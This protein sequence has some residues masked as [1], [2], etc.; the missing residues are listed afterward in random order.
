VASRKVSRTVQFDSETDARLE[1]LSTARG[2]AYALIVRELVE[3]Y[4]DQ[5]ERE[6]VAR[7]L[8]RQQPAELVATSA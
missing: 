2:E 4:I 8:R 1:R 6:E 7:L 5:Y 3:H